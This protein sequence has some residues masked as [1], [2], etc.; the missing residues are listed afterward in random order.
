M[1][2]DLENYLVKFYDFFVAYKE[3][4]RGTKDVIISISSNTTALGGSYEANKLNTVSKENDRYLIINLV[5]L[6]G[7]TT[8]DWRDTNA[9]KT[10]PKTLTNIN[11]SI[12]YR[13]RK[14]WYASPDMQ[15]MTPVVLSE[16]A[17]SSYN[18]TI[19]KIK[20]WGLLVI[21]K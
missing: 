13:G 4:L 15:E 5:N 19:P 8:T 20:Y 9:T 11:L 12:Q 3:F 21:E 10:E 7:V 16:T 17:Q 14:I 6:V 1:T 18:I 2:S